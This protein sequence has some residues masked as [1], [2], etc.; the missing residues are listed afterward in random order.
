MTA[1][2]L[3]KHLLYKHG[4]RTL[5]K[6]IP[7]GFFGQLRVPGFLKAFY[8]PLFIFYKSVALNRQYVLLVNLWILVYFLFRHHL[9]FELCFCIWKDLAF[10]AVCHAAHLRQCAA[11]TEAVRAAETWRG[12]KRSCYLPSRGNRSAPWAPVHTI[13][14]SVASSG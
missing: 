6:R 11:Q 14:V 8:L 5:R 12:Q 10:V 2:F 4:S 1:S 7:Q 13:W 3:A 9:V